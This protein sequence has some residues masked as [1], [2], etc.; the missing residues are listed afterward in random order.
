MESI[1]RLEEIK[2]PSPPDKFYLLEQYVIEQQGVSHGFVG[3]F[4]PNPSLLCG[5]M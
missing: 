2:I 4:Q 1:T 3:G 5:L